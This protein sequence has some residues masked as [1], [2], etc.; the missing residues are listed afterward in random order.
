V[1]R[2]IGG[3]GVSD[4]L[5][6]VVIADA[7]Q[8]AMAGQYKSLAD[9]FTLIGTIIGWS[10]LLNFLSYRF[11]AVRRFAFPRPMCLIKDGA[12]LERNLKQEAI[13]DDELAEMLREHEIEDIAE[14]RQALLEPDGRFTVIRKRKAAG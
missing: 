3:L 7:S 5:V 2:D 12:K 11:A 9:G 1:H 13:T 10:Y 8:N 14:V 4:M 6:L